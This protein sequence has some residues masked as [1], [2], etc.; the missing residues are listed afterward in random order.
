MKVQ[1]DNSLH[2]HRRMPLMITRWARKHAKGR[3][4]ETFPRMRQYGLYMLQ[5]LD[6][7]PSPAIIFTT[8]ATA[9][10]SASTCQLLPNRMH[11]PRK[12]FEPI[13]KSKKTTL[14]KIAFP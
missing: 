6:E 3:T 10:A 5:R 2:E 4:N 8:D 9:I 13:V 1:M 12:E 7:H 14:L 11:F